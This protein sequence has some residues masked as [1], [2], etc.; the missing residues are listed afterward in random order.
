MKVWFSSWQDQI[1]DNR[2]LPEDQWKEAPNVLLPMNFDG[3]R[4]IDGFMGWAGIILFSDKNNILELTRN[5]IDEV[6]LQSC[7]R[8]FP[9]RVGT[10]LLLDIV[11]WI[12][13]G[14]GK[15]E[16]LKNIDDLSAE[17]LRTSKCSIGTTGPKPVVD[18]IRFFREE[19]EKAVNEKKP[20]VTNG[21][22]YVSETTTP[23]QSACPTDMDI[24]EYI[25][26]I[27]D[28]NFLG[29]L[30]VIREASPM[31]NCLGRACFHPCEDACRRENVEETLAICRLK[32]FVW[33]YED[34]HVIE[35]PKN[36]NIHTREEKVAIIGAGAGGLSCAYYL[37]LRG[38]RP[39]VFE[40][41]PVPG[42]VAG[43]GI[44]SYR[45]PKELIERETQ[46]VVDQGV[47]I[48]YNTTFG[49]DVTFDS[50]RAEGFK[51]FVLA[52]GADVSKMMGAEDEELKLEGLYDGIGFLKDVV[53]NE[54]FN[55]KGKKMLTIGGGSTA[56]DV[57]RTAVRQGYESHILYRR[58]KAELPADKYE[59]RESFDEGVIY[60]F[61]VAPKRIVHDGKKVTGVEVVD[62]ELGEP[63]SSGR[64]RPVEIKGSEHVI[65]GDIV[66]SAIG[67]DPNL[68]F[69]DEEPNIQKTKWRSV[70]VDEDTFQT[71]KPD[72]FAIGDA[73][74]IGALM[75]V[76]ACGDGA[77]AA[78]G[79]DQYLNGNEVKP[80]DVQILENVIRKVGCYDPHE[81]VPMVQGFERVPIRLIPEKEKVGTFKE[82]EL[83][84]NI[85]EA[86]EEAKRC[87][88]CYQCSTVSLATK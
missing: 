57:C 51:A 86:M 13:R 43:V 77:R 11:S 85:E 25:E 82:V 18:T 38:Y 72:V 10:K 32:R 9:C 39:T 73:A 37:A 62:M 83:G 42:G 63:D 49:K 26:R 58:T 53:F 78:Q 17:I 3:N 76:V 19:Y 28:G 74:Q 24:S 27:K 2:N 52:T 40:K 35:K 66:V 16:D 29:S 68:F 81:E 54:E 34:Q 30:A 55:G 14:E 6:Q 44:P 61:L 70:K 60:H 46:F 4:K 80:T 67:Q 45:I 84:F 1:V 5:Y 56:M 21:H 22:S 75:I 71:D 23:C 87:M 50:L 31:A 65:E 41:L 12:T 15:I 36:P 48:K 79:V 69:L 33:D 8:C 47:E 88:R 20:I 7:G 59:I 64:R